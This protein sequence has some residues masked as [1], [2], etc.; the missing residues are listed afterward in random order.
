M[1]SYKVTY[2]DWK[3]R[4]KQEYI[5]ADNQK[6]AEETAMVMQGVYK[7]IRVEVVE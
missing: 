5:F 3:G 7:L 1:Y 2:V 4:E 6:M